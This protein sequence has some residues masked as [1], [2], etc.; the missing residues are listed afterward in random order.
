ML[1]PRVTFAKSPSRAPAPR[2]LTSPPLLLPVPA[3]LSLS[4]VPRLRLSPSLLPAFLPPS[5]PLLLSA[6]ARSLGSGSSAGQGSEGG[7]ACQPATVTVASR[8]PCRLGAAVLLR[9]GLAPPQSAL[10]QRWPCSSRVLRRRSSPACPPE[11]C[12][13][14]AAAQ[15]RQ[16][17]FDPAARPTA[18]AMLLPDLAAAL[19]SLL[20]PPPCT[21]ACASSGGGGRGRRRRASSVCAWWSGNRRAAAAGACACYGVSLVGA[22]GGGRGAAEGRRGRGEVEGAVCVGAGF[23]A[24]RCSQTQQHAGEVKAA[25]EFE[26]IVTLAAASQREGVAFQRWE[27]HGVQSR[28]TAAGASSA[29][30]VD[31]GSGPLSSWQKYQPLPHR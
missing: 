31:G 22:G 29:G 6:S 5:P 30:T 20:A 2:T 8:Q 25:W 17:V 14:G 1:F 16:A 4:P 11:S 15:L 3:A 7:G 23:T 21:M 13:P 26:S 28:S 9:P 18:V 12:R 27:I 24:A 19:S 10:P